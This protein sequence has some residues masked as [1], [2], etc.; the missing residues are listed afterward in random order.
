MHASYFINKWLRL[1]LHSS[2]NQ[3]HQQRNIILM[4]L[5]WL[6]AILLLTKTLVSI[7][8]KENKK[9]MSQMTC[10][11][12]P[13]ECVF[14][15]KI[16][17]KASSTHNR[18]RIN[19]PEDTDYLTPFLREIKSFNRWPHHTHYMPFWELL[20]HYTPNPTTCPPKWNLPT[21]F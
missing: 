10:T 13:S 21:D 12:I 8:N 16:V 20:R 6:N 11:C 9:L 5:R 15:K 1:L 3:Q 4:C 7:F 19:W 2:R 17:K 18:L 14:K